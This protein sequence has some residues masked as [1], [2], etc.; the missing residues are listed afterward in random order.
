MTVRI[1]GT[2]SRL[3]FDGQ[4]HSISGFTAEADRPEYDV[5][6][7]FVFKRDVEPSAE[8]TD[9]GIS[10]LG[11][12]KEDFIN[13]NPAF[14]NVFFDLTDGYV[15]ILPL[16]AVVEIAGNSGKSVYDGEPHSAEGYEIQ[17]IVCSYDAPD[18]QKF[19][20]YDCNFYTPQ[21]FRFSG[22][23]FAERNEPGITYMGL[24]PDQ[25]ENLN[26]NFGTVEFRVTDGFQ[27]ITSSDE[28]PIPEEAA[29]KKVTIFSSLKPNVYTN[30]E[31]VLSAHLEGFGACEQL[32]YRWECD[33][34][35]G[36]RPVEGGDKATLTY[37][38]NSETL[39]WKWQLTVFCR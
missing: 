38:A 18:G 13:V 22:E 33:N 19:A 34:G 3:T 28:M 36:F 14:G 2:V 15:E 35:D 9:A 32:R 24:L 25:F 29:E 16:N 7:D 20:I 21:D 23:A 1:S 11:L 6:Q 31:V 12:T 30:D 39:G 8:R 26:M 4:P 27:E 37:P 5:T 10:Y 17:S